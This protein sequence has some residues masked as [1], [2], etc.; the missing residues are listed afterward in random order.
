MRV[1]GDPGATGGKEDD[2]DGDDDDEKGGRRG[3]GGEWVGDSAE[4]RGRGGMAAG[5]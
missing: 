1:L 2:D 5:M 4:R 3:E